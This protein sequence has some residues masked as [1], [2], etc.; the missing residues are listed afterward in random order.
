MNGFGP[1]IS[2][3][4][5]VYNGAAEIEATLSSAFSQDSSLCEVVVI[6]GGSTDGTLEVLDRYRDRLAVCISEPDR[7]IYDAMNKGIS[8][9]HGEWLYFLNCGD[10][11]VDGEVLCKAAQDLRRSTASLV[12]GRVNVVECGRVVN[13]FP[14]AASAQDT[15]RQLFRTHL[16][17]QAQFVRRGACLDAG[18]FDLRFPVFSD[19][20]T[21]CKIINQ[22]GG[23]ERIDLTIADF[24]ACGVS[25]DFRRAVKHYCEAEE[26]FAAL[27]E[28][29]SRLAFHLGYMRAWLYQVRMQIAG[30]FQ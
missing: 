11:F 18:G 5:V 10:R 7:G 24:D 30:V 27:G 4:T 29:R 22:Y 12:V 8:R 9:A 1:L 16:S 19:F 26:V 28:A 21:A 17:Q 14:I 23:M 15:A 6:D 20:H 13:Q 3:I 25:S 2:V